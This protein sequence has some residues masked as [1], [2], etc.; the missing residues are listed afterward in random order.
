MKE[1]SLKNVRKSVQILKDRKTRTKNVFWLWYS[2][3]RT[4][5]RDV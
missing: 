3:T 5:N 1:N 4:R 2:G